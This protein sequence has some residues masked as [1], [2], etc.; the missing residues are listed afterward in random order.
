MGG[1]GQQEE[2]GRENASLRNRGDTGVASLLVELAKADPSGDTIRSMQRWA[3]EAILPEEVRLPAALLC[4]ELV[5][6]GGGL[7]VAT[8]YL[9]CVN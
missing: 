6:W 3:C 8:S 7:A 4:S 9:V 2:L 1:E 5:G